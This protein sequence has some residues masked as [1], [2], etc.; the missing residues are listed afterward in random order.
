MPLLDKRPQSANN[1]MQ[2]LLP[3]LVEDNTNLAITT[4]LGGEFSRLSEGGI[5]PEGLID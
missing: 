4:D 2:Q 5:P 3:T 1:A